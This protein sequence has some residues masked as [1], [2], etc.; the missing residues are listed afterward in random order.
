MPGRWPTPVRPESFITID[1]FYTATVYNKGAELVRMMKTL[2]GEKDFRRATDIYF[3]RHDGEAATVEDF[4]I[5]MEE[6]SGRDLEQ[7]RRWYS[8][9]GTPKITVRDDFKDGVYT[10]SLAQE[11]A[12]TPDQ[13]EKAPRHIPLKLALIGENGPVKEEEVI[14]LTT[15]AQTLTYSSLEQRPIASINRGFSAPVR[16]DYDLS[17]EDRLTLIRSD[18]DPFNRW[19]T[20]HALA[21][22]LIRSFA[23]EE[24]IVQAEEALF[25]YANALGILLQ[26][27]TQDPAF[28]AEVLRTPTESDIAQSVQVIDPEAI[29]AARRRFRTGLRGPLKDILHEVY[30]SN[31]VSE[32]FSPAA[33][34]AGRRTLKNVALGLLMTE[35]DDEVMTLALRQAETADNMSDEAAAVALIA[36]ADR[37]ERAHLLQAFHDKWQSETLVINKWLAWQAMSSVPGALDRIKA[38][39]VHPAFDMRNPNKVRSL[40][41]ALASSNLSVFHEASGAGYDFFFEHIRKLDPINPQIAARLLSA[42]ESW[43]RLEPTRRE[44]VGTALN[45]LADEKGLSKNVFEMA[46]RL[47]G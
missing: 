3:D 46:G 44:K 37:P 4:V 27:N 33:D 42:V 38:L 24:A 20:S 8:D 16:I 14:E 28:V 36:L 6:A 22:D 12:P 7:F 29:V 41:G 35:P 45:A 19:A 2:I 40:I 25:A 17:L 43:K 31:K 15:D 10:L 5:C 13:D 9:A 1:N 23:G 11:T 39:T 30:D 47:A 32:A 21:M 18:N 26:D 34:Q